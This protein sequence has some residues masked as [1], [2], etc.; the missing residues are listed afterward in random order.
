MG[1]AGFFSTKTWNSHGK[2][3]KSKEKEEELAI[4]LAK[5]SYICKS[6]IIKSSRKFQ[7]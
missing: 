7:S 2:E 4:N 6:V 1:V 3:A 5:N